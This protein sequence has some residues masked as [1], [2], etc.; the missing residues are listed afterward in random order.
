MVTGLYIFGILVVLL[1]AAIVWKRLTRQVGPGEFTA[2]IAA[3]QEI[4]L[5]AF[6]RKFPSLPDEELFVK[7]V[8]SRPGYSA[9]DARSIVEDAK[10]PATG[11]LRFSQV[12]YWIAAREF[13]DRLGRFPDGEEMLEMMNAIPS[14]LDEL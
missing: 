12:V 7:I 9:D 10:D 6:R 8:E 4:A 3:T 11:S 13:F 2:G 14:R 1:L 5:H